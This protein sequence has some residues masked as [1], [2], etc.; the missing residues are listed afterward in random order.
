L[1]RRHEEN[2]FGDAVEATM[3]LR[4]RSELGEA[5]WWLRGREIRLVIVRRWH[6]FS[7][8]RGVWGKDLDFTSSIINT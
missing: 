2:R 7:S 5:A 4:R 8:S 3:R 1:G 6:I